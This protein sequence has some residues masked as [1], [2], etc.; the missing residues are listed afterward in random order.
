MWLNQWSSDT[1]GKWGAPVGKDH[2]V[3][4][5]D[6]VRGHEGKEG[7]SWLELEAPQASNWTCAQGSRRG[8]S[9]CLIS[10]HQDQP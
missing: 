6:A 10:W 9:E 4:S 3:G 2:P 1:L 8:P 5:S 7:R